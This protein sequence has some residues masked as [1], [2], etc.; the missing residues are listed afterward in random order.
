M[1]ALA[2]VQSPAVLRWVRAPQ[3]ERTRAGLTRLL[4]AA[5]ELLAERSF[6]EIS[7]AEIAKTAGSSVGAF[8]RR[9]RDKDGLLHALH[10]RFSADARATADEALEP[11]RWAGARL[12]DIVEAFTAFLVQTHRER[13][14]LFTAF[15]RRGA[16]DTSMRQRTEELF[17]YIGDRLNEL[18]SEHRQRINHPDPAL[19]ASL[20]LH[21]MIGTLSNPMRI[22][23]EQ[24]ARDD[25]RL[26]TE[27][28]RMFTSYIGVK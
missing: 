3:Q 6:E 13:E 12:E 27:L 25:A 16:V 14:G 19:A 11:P 9:F 22:P 10:E 2:T 17:A 21:M 4:D 24:I 23:I 5:E 28:A 18:L 26:V 20:G 15:M 7:I 8:Y 1:N